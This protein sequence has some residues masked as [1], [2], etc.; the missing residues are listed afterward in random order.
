MLERWFYDLVLNE[1]CDLEVEMVSMVCKDIIREIFII[2]K[3]IGNEE[4]RVLVWLVVK[5][6]VIKL[7]F[8]VVFKGVK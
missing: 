4:V 2:L 7:K 1:L 6:N 8:L 5:F 3:I